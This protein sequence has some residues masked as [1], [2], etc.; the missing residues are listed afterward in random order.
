MAQPP[1]EQVGT[2]DEAEEL[3][4]R[5]MRWAGFRD[6]T[7]TTR[8]AD[9]GIDVTAGSAVA[10][11][12]FHMKPAGRPAMQQLYGA[13]RSEGKEPFFF[14]YAGYSPQASAFADQVGIALFQFT[15]DG[16][17]HALNPPAEAV[18]RAGEGLGPPVSSSTK[19]HNEFIAEVLGITGGIAVLVVGWPFKGFSQFYVAVM[20]ALAAVV[21][22]GVAV[23]NWLNARAQRLLDLQHQST[24]GPPPQEPLDST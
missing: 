9:G 15:S 1:P 20:V 22:I 3:A 18:A 7:T 24:H 19:K 5:W 23:G 12:K 17:I 14:S 10:Q 6:A 8:G 4:A 2:P 11:V 13:A 21:I 16:L